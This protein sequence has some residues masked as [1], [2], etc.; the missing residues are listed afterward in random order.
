M[1]LKS[2]YEIFPN[3]RDRKRFIKFQDEEGECMNLTQQ[4]VA[5][6]RYFNCNI[7]NI[8][9][10]KGSGRRAISKRTGLPEYQIQIIFVAFN[11]S[12][13]NLPKLNTKFQI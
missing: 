11:R 9:F 10:R 5:Y 6:L 7:K 3:A 13:G 1:P 8:Y 2:I 12:D 4:I